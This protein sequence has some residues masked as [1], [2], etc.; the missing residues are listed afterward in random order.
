MS[1]TIRNERTKGYLD[2][3][4]TERRTRKLI[5]CLKAD[6]LFCDLENIND[7]NE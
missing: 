3:L 1:K 2:K 6:E 5:R 4:Q 7:N